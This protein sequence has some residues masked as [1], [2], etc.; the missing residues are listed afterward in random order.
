MRDAVRSGRL[1]PGTRLPSS[2]QL[3]ADLGLARNTVADAYGDLVAVGWLTARRGS[4]T[5]VADRTI[6]RPVSVRSSAQPP[7]RPVNLATT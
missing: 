3:A 2:R 4:G 6:T 5:L 7:S 1:A